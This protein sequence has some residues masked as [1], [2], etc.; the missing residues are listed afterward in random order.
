M[1]KQLSERL[2]KKGQKAAM[3]LTS[4][5]AAGMAI[6]GNLTYSATKTFA[7]YIGEGLY[8]ELQD[9]VDVIS[10]RPGNVDTNM[11]PKGNKGGDYISP[12]H[13][14]SYCLRDL[15]Y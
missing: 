8:Y 4:S 11:N 2:E 7:T 3:I 13:S 15:G 14:A 1:S 6:P 12:A 10:F 9:K 5:I